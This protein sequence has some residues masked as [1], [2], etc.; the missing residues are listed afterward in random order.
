MEKWNEM[1]PSESNQ[2]KSKLIKS[3]TRLK[4]K[5]RFKRLLQVIYEVFYFRISVVN[6]IFSFPT[7]NSLLQEKSTTNRSVICST[8]AK[9]LLVFY[10]LMLQI[11]EP[12]MLMKM[13]CRDA[14]EHETGIRLGTSPE[15]LFFVP[16]FYIQDRVMDS[17]EIQTMR[18]S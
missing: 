2:I 4:V 18:I 12:K 9:C 15:K 13:K 10:S 5:T 1:G 8:C 3:E 16:R 11:Q 14:S 17:F 7:M 6:V